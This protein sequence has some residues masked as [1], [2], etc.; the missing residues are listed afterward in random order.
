M[1]QIALLKVNLIQLH[2]TRYIYLT[3]DNESVDLL[4]K[5]MILLLNA[6]I[7]TLLKYVLFVRHKISLVFVRALLTVRSCDGRPCSRA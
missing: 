3:T 7:L 1:I 5:K 6:V 2:G 4:D